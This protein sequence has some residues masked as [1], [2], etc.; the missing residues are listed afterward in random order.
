MF[1]FQQNK[2]KTSMMNEM[3]CGVQEAQ[4]THFLNAS[5]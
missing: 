5:Q 1:A 2:P 3:T 4:V